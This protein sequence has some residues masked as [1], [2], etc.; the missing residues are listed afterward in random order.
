M[1]SPGLF[2][3]GGFV[4]SRNSSFKPKLMPGPNA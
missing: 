4:A 1:G 3:F 2:C